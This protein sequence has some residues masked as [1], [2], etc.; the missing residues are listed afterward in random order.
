MWVHKLK[1]L[2]DQFLLPITLV[3]NRLGVRPYQITLAGTFCGLIALFFLFTD[4]L[5]FFLFMTAMLIL[6]ILD[7]SLARY[8][9]EI[10]WWED[11]LNDRIIFG[12]I[13]LKSVFILGTGLVFVGLILHI[14]VSIL[15]WRQKYVIFYSESF[16]ILC[17]FL[18]YYTLAVWILV[19]VYLLDLVIIFFLSKV[20][21]LKS[22]LNKP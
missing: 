10:S 5:L 3:L 19:I 9:K 18:Q 13:L 8:T 20:R 7:G 1:G 14:L 16:V 2:K 17:Y 21:S 12:L 6:D 4:N 11:Y 15:N 22:V